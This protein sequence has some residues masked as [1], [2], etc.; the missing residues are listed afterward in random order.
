MLIIMS[1]AM[2]LGN[3]V[4]PRIDEE[5]ASIVKNEKGE[6]VEEKGVNSRVEKIESIYTQN[7]WMLL[8]GAYLALLIFNL[9]FDFEKR[10]D[11]QWFWEAA[12][13][14]LA[15]Y[16]WDNLDAFRSNSWFPGVVL[17]SGIII[18]AFYFYF[19]DK[20]LKANNKESVS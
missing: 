9:S 5:A 19:L 7:F 17:E 11:L 13:T 20:K 8:F 15:L 4:A 12:L 10:E 2:T 16:T 3:E 14:F 6:V 1:P 18:Y